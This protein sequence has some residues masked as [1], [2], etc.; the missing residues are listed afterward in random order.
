MHILGY[1]AGMIHVDDVEYMNGDLEDIMEY[2]SG[3]NW[4]YLILTLWYFVAI[5]EL[6]NR[7][8]GGE[9]ALNG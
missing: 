7:Q 5:C 2:S 6:D 8:N 3:C 9:D 4:I 1:L